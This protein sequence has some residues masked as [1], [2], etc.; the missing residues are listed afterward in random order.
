MERV[1]EAAK[2][3]KVTHLTKKLPKE[4]SNGVMVKWRGLVVE[5]VDMEDGGVFAP[6]PVVPSSG[7]R[8]LKLLWRGSRQPELL[9]VGPEGEYDGN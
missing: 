6:I 2:A 4:N 9:M 8:G 7:G 3:Q 5:V 1:H